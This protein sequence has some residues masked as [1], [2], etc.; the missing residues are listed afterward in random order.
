MIKGDILD[1]NSAAS[2]LAGITAR[3]VSH[4]DVADYILK[5]LKNPSDFGKTPLLAY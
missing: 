1:G 3:R 4:L 5:Q 2:A